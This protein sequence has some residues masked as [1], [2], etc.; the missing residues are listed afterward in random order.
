MNEARKALADAQSLD[1]AGKYL[2][3]RK[4]Y[5]RAIRLNPH[6][7][8]AFEQYSLFLYARGKYKEGAKAMRIGLKLNP[9]MNLLNAYLAMHLYRRGRVQEAWLKLRTAEAMFSKK[10]VLQAIYAQCSML[11]EEY[12]VAARAIKNY[13]EIRPA[14]L[15]GK[16][17]AF[18]IQLALA[19]MRSGSIKEAEKELNK[20]LYKRP[21]SVRAR[22]ARAELLLLK[23]RCAQ[24][25]EAYRQ[26]VPKIKADYLMIY[27]GQAYLCMGRAAD[28]YRVATAYLNKKGASLMKLLEKPP[29]R[30]TK[31]TRVVKYL[32]MGLVLRGDSSMRLKR[33]NEA[34]DNYGKAA[35]LAGGA[36]QVELRV[37]GAHYQ[38]REYDKTLQKLVEPLKRTTPDPA[39]L[40]L[41]LRAAVRVKKLPLA[42]SCADRLV[43]RKGA[44]ATHLYYAG[45]AYNS[46]GRFDQAASLLERGVVTDPKH[47]GARRELIRAYTYRAKRSVRERKAAAGEAFLKKALKLS[48]R[49]LVLRRNLALILLGQ[50]RYEEALVQA[51][52]AYN[53]NPRDSAAQRLAGRALAALG[54]HAQ[55]LVYYSRALKDREPDLNT[56]RIFIE[57]AA[58]R[59]AEGAVT[60]GLSDLDQALKIA[61]D[62]KDAKLTKMI[63]RNIVRAHMHRGRQHL[64]QGKQVGAWKEFNTALKQ[65][66]LLPKSE[67]PVIQASAIFAAIAAGQFNQARR[68][69]RRYRATF[70]AA[71][72]APYDK[73]SAG[74][75]AAYTD[76][77]SKATAVKVRGAGRLEKLA[78]KLPSP[79][80]ERLKDMAGSAYAHAGEAYFRFGRSRLAQVNLLKAR[81]LLRV[82]PLEVRHN[83]AV[84]DYY[85][86]KRQEAIRVLQ[87][88]SPKI[89]IAWCNLA[90][91]EEEKGAMREAYKLFTVCDQRGGKLRGLKAILEIKRQIFGKL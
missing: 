80:S 90:V 9:G 61:R 59:I 47:N 71:L 41:A 58:S 62:H 44:N 40:T 67:R 22:V 82:I 43:K 64:D 32:R 35:T 8:N 68:L 15:S 3:A 48:P 53:V 18:R 14:G 86:G 76:Y 42:I 79:A 28:A 83:S 75:L 38:L 69:T 16:D 17:F 33:Y 65:A 56:A 89:P 63:Q 77:S 66:K 11:I 72:A 4:Q 30:S 70:G 1:Q 39:V 78:A 24:S 6:S 74:L 91:H 10:F 54:K 51:E 34:L 46:A 26:I 60:Q 37:A 25:L 27:I 19:L 5:L 12:S 55:A 87:A 49:S 13:L 23:R 7:E 50:K 73:I 85:S 57:S 2:E 81:R 29:T 45:M 31:H 84:A 88:T 21:D 36:E 52:R 20:V